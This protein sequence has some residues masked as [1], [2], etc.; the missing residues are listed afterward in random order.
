MVWSDVSTWSMS[1]SFSCL[2]C[3]SCHSCLGGSQHVSLPRCPP[4]RI[5]RPWCHGAAGLTYL[6]NRLGQLLLCS[7]CAPS[8]CFRRTGTSPSLSCS[9]PVSSGRFS[10]T[11]VRSPLL[12]PHPPDVSFTRGERAVL[13]Q[14]PV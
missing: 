12:L 10:S 13:F 6:L 5:A 4:T 11:Y 8:L 14:R 1:M 9:S 2:L 3:H 7:C